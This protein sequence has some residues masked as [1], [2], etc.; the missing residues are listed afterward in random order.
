M[1]T[2]NNAR[3]DLAVQRIINVPKR[4]IGATTLGRV[5]DYADN[6]GISLYEA[7]RVLKR[8]LLLEE[9]CQ[10]RWLC[11]FYTDAEEQGRCADCGGN[12]AGGN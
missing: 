9:A 11:N 12:P 1:K 5:Q 4:G 3:D 10:D 6:M 8:F 2:I 7:L